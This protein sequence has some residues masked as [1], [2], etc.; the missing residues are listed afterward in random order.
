MK[1]HQ[2]FM[3]VSALGVSGVVGC[4]TSCGTHK[5]LFPNAPWNKN[6]CT[7]PTARPG[8]AAVGVVPGQP[9]PLGADTAVTPPPGS[10]F[11][12]APGSTFAPAPGSAVTPAPGSTF[13]PSPQAPAPSAPAPSAL[14]IRG[15]GPPPA[16]SVWHAP[17]TNGGVQLANPEAAP[18][19]DSVRLS[20]PEAPASPR[21][22]A[23]SE[24]KTPEPPTAPSPN[25]IRQ[26]V[27]VYERVASGLRPTNLEGLNWLKANGYRAVLYLRQA[28]DDENTDRQAME[29]RDLKYFSLEVTPQN[30]RE[31]LDQFNL[32]VNDSA[33]YPLFVYSKSSMVTGSLWYLRFRTVDKQT[34]EAARSKAAT[35]GLQEEQTEANRPTWLAI[36]KVLEQIR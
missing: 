2:W 1:K 27:L 26:F 15:Y 12:P 6:C 10:T 31:S 4:T 33:N 11:A 16:E 23:V 8:V 32:I 28:G 19:R 7:G 36:Q 3:I 24:S 9:M 29:R 20:A 17:T 22:P 25:D 5:P 14:E 21:S 18:P 13:A 30:L 35:L 34:D